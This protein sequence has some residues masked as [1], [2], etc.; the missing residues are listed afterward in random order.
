[1]SRSFGTFPVLSNPA[2]LYETRSRSNLNKNT[3]TIDSEQL[4]SS[5]LDT[6]GLAGDGKSEPARAISSKRTIDNPSRIVSGKDLQTR[7]LTS[8]HLALLGVNG[9][10]QQKL[11]SPQINCTQK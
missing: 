7:D 8:Q 4:I 3:V 1:M 2:N 5:T 6:T 11:S 9:E 10:K